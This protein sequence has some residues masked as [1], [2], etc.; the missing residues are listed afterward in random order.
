LPLGHSGGAQMLKEQ[1]G[2]RQ[3][4]TYRST[5]ARVNSSGAAHKLGES[6]SSSRDGDTGPRP[7]AMRFI[8][9]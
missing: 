6:L 1:I 5:R 9:M 4:L 7:F 3:L 8:C 2:V